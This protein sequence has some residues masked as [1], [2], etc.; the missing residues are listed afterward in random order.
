MF[1]AW[2]VPAGRRPGP[3]LLKDFIRL[4]F[5]PEALISMVSSVT[6]VK[7]SRKPSIIACFV[8]PTPALHGLSP[9]NSKL[10]LFQSP[11]WDFTLFPAG[12]ER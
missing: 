2:N 7:A 6:C 1:F 11:A 5:P 3:P 4:A 8:P 12:A 10:S 9:G